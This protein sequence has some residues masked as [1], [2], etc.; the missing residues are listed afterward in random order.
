MLKPEWIRPE[1]WK[2]SS[3]IHAAFS[4]AAPFQETPSPIPGYNFAFSPKEDPDRVQRNRSQLLE[5]LGVAESHL[6]LCGQVHGTQVHIA[7]QGG[8]L[9]EGDGLVTATPGLAVGVL[10]ADC[11]A[12]LL[13]DPIAKVVG[14]LHAGWRGAA[15]GII[16]QGLEKMVSLGADPSRIQAF[17]GPCI[18]V[19]HFE[20]GEEVASLFPEHCVQ[21]T[22]YEKPQANLK[23]WIRQQLLDQGLSDKAIEIHPACTFAD[24]SYYSYRRQKEESGRM[25]ALIWFT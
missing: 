4:L 15:G 10:V 14:A 16:Q 18:G 20:V 21:R 22:G 6:A 1:L 9:G 12:I 8:Y 24:T 25:I 11:G 19:E 5:A 2:N 17:L 23:C 13:A 3:S 7:E